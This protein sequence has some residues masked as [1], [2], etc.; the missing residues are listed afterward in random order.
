MHSIKHFLP[1]T[2]LIVAFLCAPSIAEANPIDDTFFDTSGRTFTDSN[3]ANLNVDPGNLNLIDEHGGPSPWWKDR[4][5]DIA[6]SFLYGACNNT[7]LQVDIKNTTDT[8]AI[9]HTMWNTV[10]AF[11]QNDYDWKGTVLAANSWDGVD[12]TNDAAIYFGHIDPGMT[13]TRYILLQN[14]PAKP[15]LLY[16]SA[17]LD[18][19][20]PGYPG[21]S[22]VSVTHTPEPLSSILFVT[23]GTLLGFKRYWRNRR[24][25]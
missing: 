5:E 24:K 2:M 20:E 19:E 7:A 22:N 15:N 10:L 17:G 3:C 12:S 18:S 9:P 21:A 25:I 13:K 6:L 11:E 14:N 8:S 16:D 23:G 4:S 1:V